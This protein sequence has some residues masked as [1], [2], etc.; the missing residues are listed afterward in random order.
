MHFT[1]AELT[2]VLTTHGYLILFPII[3]LEGPVA[4]IISGFLVSVGIFNLLL[5]YLVVVAADLTGDMFYYAVGK[6]WFRSLVAKRFKKLK[7]A[8]AKHKGKILFFG[9]LSSFIGPTVMLGAGAISV[10]FGEFMYLNFVGSLFKSILLILVGYYAGGALT[11]L[12]KNLDLYASLGL[13]ALSIIFVGIYILVTK[14]SEKYFRKL[15]GD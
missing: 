1:I 14:L 15:Q 10:P 2:A 12:G 5:T 8:Y 7:G 9:K 6:S 11:R 4:T 3:V 13:L